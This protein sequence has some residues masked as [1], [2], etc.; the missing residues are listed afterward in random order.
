MDEK[1]FKEILKPIYDS[2]DRFAPTNRTLINFVNDKARG[3]GLAR[4][5][6]KVKFIDKSELSA[7]Q[8]TNITFV[9]FKKFLSEQNYNADDVAALE[10]EAETF[11]EEVRGKIEKVYG[12]VRRYIVT[13]ELRKD[14]VKANFRKI[15]TLTDSANEVIAKEIFSLA[16]E[17]INKSEHHSIDDIENEFKKINN[18]ALTLLDIVNKETAKKAEHKKKDQKKTPLSLFDRLFST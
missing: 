17:E 11:L 9:N 16:I 12:E 2:A 7:K 18:I 5:I 13:S 6:Y 4:S 1:T 8:L 10:K 14:C 15:P 3:E